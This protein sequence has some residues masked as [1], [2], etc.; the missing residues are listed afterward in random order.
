MQGQ[1]TME[2]KVITPPK[3]ALSA[4]P[5]LAVG[6][7][8]H[9]AKILVATDFSPASD[10]A[11]DYAI[12]LARRYGAKIYLTHV[13]LAEGYPMVAP[14]LLVAREASLRRQA[15]EALYKIADSHRLMGVDYDVLIEEGNFWPTVESLVE[16]HGVDLVVAGTHSMGVVQKVLLGSNAEQIF[17]Q[18]RVPILTVGPNA[19]EETWY[20]AEF[21]HILFAT[22]F[23]PGAEREA[24]VALS[25]AREHRARLT[26]LHVLTGAEESMGANREFLLRQ[27][28]ELIP[29]Q[30]DGH[31]LVDFQVVHGKPVEKILQAKAE[32]NVDL[33]VM[34]AKPR[35]GVVG[36]A[37]RATAYEVVKRAACPV[38]TV[39]SCAS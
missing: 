37:A 9:L 7:E 24:A 2:T 1:G 27:M 3:E 38:L 26:V 16:T 11:L 32:L 30:P 35:R 23:G 22:D 19:P 15:R 5:A 18:A 21:K 12:S 31:C 14:E 36:H 34:G 39:R 25:L 29:P 33:I 4:T 6:S 17:R 10:R 28:R 8:F 20:E 13:I